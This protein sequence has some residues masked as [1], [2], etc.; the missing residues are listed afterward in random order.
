[1][2]KCCVL[3]AAGGIG[4]PLSLLLKVNTQISSL[5]CYDVNPMTTGVVMDLSHVPSGAKAECFVGRDL[6]KAL[7]GSS[8]VLILAGMPQKLGMT[9]DDLFNTNASIIKML[10]TGVAESCP[11]AWVLVVSDP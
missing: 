4:Q 7:D 5:A 3:G 2:V 11:D 1:M 9:D 8:M 6:Q 10:V